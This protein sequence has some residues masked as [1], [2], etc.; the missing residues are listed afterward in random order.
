MRLIAP[1]AVLAILLVG[2]WEAL[3]RGGTL[4]ARLLPNEYAAPR[5]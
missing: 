3:S 1:P 2:G 5:V 4:S